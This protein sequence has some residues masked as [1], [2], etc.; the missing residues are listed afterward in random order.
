MDKE[1]EDN[2]NNI[3]KFED[4]LSYLVLFYKK[5]VRVYIKRYYKIRFCSYFRLFCDY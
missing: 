2:K 4:F 1:F 3:N 5:W